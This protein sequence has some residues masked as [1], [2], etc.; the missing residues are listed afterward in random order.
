VTWEVICGFQSWSL[1]LLLGWEIS[2]GLHVGCL[3]FGRYPEDLLFARS[4][5]NLTK[6]RK[7]KL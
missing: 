7:V 4:V 6:L 3:Q 2:D 1:K 5:N